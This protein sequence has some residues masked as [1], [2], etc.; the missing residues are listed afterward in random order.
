MNFLYTGFVSDPPEM[1]SKDNEWIVYVPGGDRSA[2]PLVPR[3][4]HSREITQTDLLPH[5][6]YRNQRKFKYIYI[7]I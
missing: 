3:L 4:L 2:V 1:F 5:K 7:Y 6:R